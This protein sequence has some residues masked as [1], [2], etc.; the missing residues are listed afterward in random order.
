MEIT[1]VPYIEAEEQPV[2][3]G[4]DSPDPLPFPK[5]E[6][7]TSIKTTVSLFFHFHVPIFA[8]K[9]KFI[10]LKIIYFNITKKIWR[11]DNIGS[12]RFNFPIEP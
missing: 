4:R 2:G 12:E 11:N 6:K 10:Y 9:R 8:R 5:W 1:V 7:R 3:K